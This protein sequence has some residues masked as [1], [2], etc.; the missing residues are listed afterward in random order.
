MSTVIALYIAN[1]KEFV[2]DRAAIFWTMAFPVLFIVLFGII[3]NAPSSSYD[4]GIVNLDTGTLGG[5]FVQTFKNVESSGTNLFKVT[6][7]TSL[8][9][10]LSDLKAGKHDMVIV[11]PSTLTADAASP[12]P[13]QIPVYYD[14]SKS[15]SAQIELSVVQGV[16]TGYSAQYLHSVPHL[17]IQQQSI[18]T[19][20]LTYIAFLVPGILA[21]SLMQL[22]LFGTAPAIVS[23]RQDGV[24]RRL[25]ATPLPRWMLL[26]SQVMLRLTIGI[27]QTALIIG[28]GYE[29]FNVQVEGNWFAFIGIVLLGALTFVGIGYFIASIART[30]EAASGISSGI[31]FPMMFLSG[32]FFPVASLASVPVLAVIIKLLPLTYLGDALRQI[33]VSGVPDFPLA[34]DIAVLAGWFIVCSLLSIRFFKWE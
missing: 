16:I 21:L 26:T 20:N 22:G 30:V 25:G 23:L 4:I 10:A 29:W 33:T 18:Q 8:D 12:N 11:V 31:N 27:V 28:I 3:F 6:T 14:P 17:N 7:Y 1:I 15:S 2:R 9:P 19:H 5:Q 32:V 34:V 13:D 24:L